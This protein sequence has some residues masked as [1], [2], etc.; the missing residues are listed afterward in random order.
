MDE[1]RELR[2]LTDNFHFFS[3][4][5]DAHG[6]RPQAQS[7]E[8]GDPVPTVGLPDMARGAGIDRNEYSDDDI[9]LVYEIVVRAETIL[10]E[11]LTPSSRLPTHALF[12][13]YDE[14][15]PEY[16]LDPSE[17]HISKLVFMVGGVKE[18]DSVLD[19]FKQIMAKMNITLDIEGQP[20]SEYE[21][22]Y[23]VE[24]QA[25]LPD[26]AAAYHVNRHAG[27]AHVLGDDEFDGYKS[28][29]DSMPESPAEALDAE[30]ERHLA[31]KAEAFRRRHHAQFS[32]VSILR[33]WH[34]TSTYLENLCAQSEAGHEEEL[35][36]GI[37]DKIRI[38]RALAAAA[39]DPAPGEAP[40]NTYSKRMETVSA[41]AREIY[42]IKKTIAKWR[43]LTGRTAE[44]R[45]EARALA[46][47]MALQRRDSEEF[48]ENSHLARLAQRTYRNLAMSR[49]FSAWSNRADE[50]VAKADL[51]AKTYEM[52][53]K[54]KALGF[55]KKG[56]A[57]DAMR[58]LL[59]S[60]A[61]GPSD[62]VEEVRDSTPL[63]LILPL[64]SV[65]GH[66]GLPEDAPRPHTSQGQPS[67]AITAA[68]PPQD[69]SSVE[70]QTASATMRPSTVIPTASEL[71]PLAT[72][73]AA[74]G[75]TTFMR[76][77]MQ[78]PDVSTIVEEDDDDP[79]DDD[80]LDE[81]TKLARRH[82]LRMRYFGAWE[83]YTSDN[84][85]KVEQFED[86]R[87]AQRLS[88]YVS[89]WREEN[90]SI[91]QQAV[92]NRLDFEE[93]RVYQRAIETISKWRENTDSAIHYESGTLQ[94]YADRAEYYQRI[95]TALPVLRLKV[96]LAEQ[97]DSLLAYYAQRSNYYLRA[98]QALST[99]REMAPPI[100]EAHQLQQQYSDRANYYYRTRNTIVMWKQKAKQ[101]RKDRL[102]E[103]HME[104]RRIVKKG[105]GQRCIKQWRDE[106]ISSYDRCEDMN[107]ALR[108]A[109]E[110]REWRHVSRALDT[111]RLRA[112]ERVDAVF[113]GEDMLVQKALSRW[114]DQ[115]ALQV[116]LQVEAEGRW[117][118]K[119]KSR[120]LKN[121]NLSS[122]QGANR[123]EM[124]ANALE[125]KARRQL[126]QG[127]ETWYGRTADKLVPIELP[128]GTYVNMGQVVEGAHR[129]ATEERARGLL[130]KWRATTKARAPAEAEDVYAPTP[131][132][133]RLLLA[134]LGRRETTTPLA[135]VP[136]R[137]RFQARDSA[138]GRSDFT[139][140][141]ARSERPRN[142]R[143]SWAP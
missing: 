143:V 79:P 67:R 90:A 61:T 113:I 55:S 136:S 37:P 21:R 17:R 114:R 83:R 32:A 52:S 75:N 25:D 6:L 28:G 12:L 124:V 36:D 138:M 14:I 77:P 73:N 81:R 102:R 68:P 129:R 33:R 11:E 84:V 47:H 110:D 96:D 115:A 106:L 74:A 64:R 128:N 51:A 103:A 93:A 132:R 54:A 18:Y 137:P 112:Q 57:L 35:L 26:V 31:D 122:V 46:E 9:K 80:Q 43:H 10:A 140:R 85:A 53:L 130:Q 16:G 62:P 86:K 111:W 142:L 99:W 133:P 60:K 108:E 92:E 141:A 56:S 89:R 118:V 94:L 88:H 41:R 48:K 24:N 4:D 120:A 91:R 7:R 3:D 101:R 121:W 63:N 125:K 50:E 40:A 97:K 29:A 34:G 135:P 30:R 107:A 117:D 95:T 69:R 66:S 104:T 44:R 8:H 131:G 1:I 5:D 27:N 127:F 65:V 126:R 119:T 123:P 98:T 19:K 71:L 38:W 58:R 22:D 15:L 78:P 45:R 100:C 116:D 109:V 72:A 134:S 13:A 139:A 23:T 39:A 20:D 105:M 70:D 42:L 2:E 87:K 76:P 49:A 82:I 59:A